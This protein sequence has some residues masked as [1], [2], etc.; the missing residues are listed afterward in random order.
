MHYSNKET[1]KR[2]ET[3]NKSQALGLGDYSA[4]KN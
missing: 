1:L 4:Q 3:T 2:E